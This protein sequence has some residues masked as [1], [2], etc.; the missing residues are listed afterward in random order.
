[1][2]NEYDIHSY[3]DQE[4]F[5]MLNLI[6]PSDRE[7][8][9]TILQFMDKYEKKSKRLY[10]FF[11]SMYDRFFAEEETF[12]ETFE[13]GFDDSTSSGVDNSPAGTA[14]RNDVLALV[15]GDANVTES[16]ADEKN[17]EEYIVAQ[18]LYNTGAQVSE[19]LIS[20]GETK[21]NILEVSQ[22]DYKKDSFKLNPVERKTY[23][24][25]LSVDSQ[26][27]EDPTSTS[28]TNFTMNLS[29]GIENVISMK[30][31]SVQIPYT[32]YTINST[33]GSNF[34][35]IKGN[36]PG[37]NNG[38][39]DIKIEIPS[40]T[41]T[42]N[43]FVTTIQNKFDFFKA[44]RSQSQNIIN[45]AIYNS[46]IDLSFGETKIS[47]NL[48]SDN[49]KIVFEFDLKKKYN[50]TDYQLYFPIWSTPNVIGTAK[51]L[52]I[53]SFLGYNYQY[54]Y[55]FIAYSLMNII[56]PI[57][58][59]SESNSVTKYNLSTSN[60]F[61]TIYQYIG[62]HF[63][64]PNK[65][66]IQTI[67][68]SLET[69]GPYSRTSIENIVKTV[70]LNTN[71]F[72]TTMTS[73]KRVDNITD[74]LYKYI[75]NSHYEI[76]IKFNRKTIDQIDN[77]KI[78]IVF[79]FEPL[80]IQYPIWVGNTS[81]FCFKTNVVELN[82]VISETDT[83][84]TN[85]IIDP[86][87]AKII[88]ECIKSNY[89][90]PENTRTVTVASSLSNGFLT[91]YLFNDYRFAINTAI[92]NMNSNTITTNLP[93]G[94]FNQSGLSIDSDKAKFKFDITREFTQNTYIVDLSSC[95]LSQSPFNFDVSLQN[96]TDLSS[97]Y[98]FVQAFSTVPQITINDSNNTLVLIPKTNGGGGGG[99]GNQNSGNI[100]LY[101]TN[102]S[103]NTLTDFIDGINSDFR[104]FKDSD[105]SPI[106]QNSSISFTNTIMTLVVR[107]SKILTESDY[108]VTFIDD[109]SNN[110]WNQYLF[111]DTSYNLAD[112]MVLSSTHSEIIGNNKVFDN[113]ITL[114]PL[115]NKIIFKPYA[116]GVADPEGRND[117]VIELPLESDNTK[118]YTREGLI[119]AIQTLFTNT[120]LTMGST[121]S[122]INDG[123][124]QY[125]NIRMN[126]N[127]TYYS[128]D[129]KLVF[130]DPYSF[131]YCNVGV[132][133][134]AT[135]DSTLGWLL[136]FQSFTEYVLGDFKQISVG[137]NYANNVY[138]DGNYI[139]KFSYDI[140][141]KKIAIRGDT[142]LNT[143]LY[144]YF[145]IV[146]DDFIQNH[147]NAGIITISS[148]EK[149]V[150]L[151]SYSS[152]L[153][154][155]CDPITGKKTAVSSTNKFNT[156]VNSRQLYAANQILEDKR[157]KTKSYASGPYMKDV[158]ALV[159]LKLSGMTFGQTY[160]E[161]GGTMQNQD[162]KYFGPVRI[163]KLSVKLMTDKGSVIS[164]N[165]AN[166]SFCIICEILN[167]STI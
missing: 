43:S 122:L 78:A 63:T 92:S 121:I 109:T 60:N 132:A 13:E 45:D 154:F 20:R 151:P 138:N 110:S 39:H 10:N 160:M 50:E 111:M 6:N 88:I 71:Y 47:Y 155:Q 52:T 106:L 18:N 108:K 28:A 70:I 16:N 117:I 112:Y 30:L 120:P 67:P 68:I 2:N 85:Y 150:S 62:T 144:N 116:N 130:Y 104:H 53:P 156:Q 27:R 4:C 72:D 153:S 89:N 131:V 48:N 123:N 80:D 25:M 164:L 163:Q 166:W 35:Y 46:V 65:I 141:T 152:R 99:F 31:Y 103:Y 149:D 44:I 165:G 7:L 1:M 42:A 161:F 136:G 9:M 98:T 82:E 14:R 21:T 100:T 40:G 159:P 26:F 75:N 58:G 49:N 101:F 56:P 86:S 113:Q 33:F 97:G 158:F 64:D 41:Y 126:I 139:N 133:Q 90:V 81:C 124:L 125:T 114:T 162:R 54:Y 96:L 95:F 137:D 38:D 57:V 146:L 37:I 93:S 12:E 102:T 167:N 145:L 128:E 134:N 59:D 19:N 143:N 129:F 77:S 66:I 84:L 105:N 24:K 107:I 118:T 34:F 115:N 91:G 142:V 148:L 11:D 157:T 51:S 61:V 3:S 55:P 15:K 8:E 87:H 29:E 79:P 94:E 119:N 69:T 17:S 5:N 135:W 83:L 23:F 76:A 74:P 22:V 147:V 32:W 36:S 140:N 73:F 127:K